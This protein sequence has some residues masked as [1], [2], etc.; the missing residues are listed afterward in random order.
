MTGRRLSWK[1][2]VVAAGLAALGYGTAQLALGGSATDPISVL[3][4]LGGALIVHDGVLGPLAVLVG[5]GLVRATARRR[6]VL[7][8]IAGGLLVA[9]CV[10]LVAL[11]ALLTPG[12]PDNPT[13]TPRDYR[14]G[15]LVLL[16]ADLLVT[17]GLALVVA[18]RSGQRSR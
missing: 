10:I 12:V 8:V 14:S 9:V 7:P 1:V 16:A 18:R 2:P 15:L 5:W 11:P 6:S 3:V 17:A 13:A 4:W